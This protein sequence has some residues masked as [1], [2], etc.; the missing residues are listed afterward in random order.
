MPAPK[1]EPGRRLAP[2]DRR[3]EIVDA[4]RRLFSMRPYRS[5]ST[6]EI[7]AEAGVARSLVHHY[8]GGIRG[9]FLAVAA[10]GAL[11]LEQARTAGPELSFEERT[12]HNVAAHLDVIAEHRE[13]WMALVGQPIDPADADIAALVLAARERAVEIT[14][15]ANRDLVRD[16]PRARFALRC[17]SDFTIAATRAWLLGEQTR[18]ETEALLLTTGRM[19]LSTVI[20][21]LSDDHA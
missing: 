8:F 12:A 2:D 6:T 21:T 9:V 17:F 7:A 1:P 10:E 18:E 15:N 20:P 14:L 16:T 13:T 11:A 3:Q 19:L 5:V 4:A